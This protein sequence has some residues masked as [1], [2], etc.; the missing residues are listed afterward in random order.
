[1]LCFFSLNCQKRSEKAQFTIGFSQCS[2]DRWRD[3]MNSEMRRELAFHP[4]INFDFRLS[5][6]NNALQ[7][8]QI[9]ALIDLKVDLLI[10]SPN[11]AKPLTPI[12]DEAFKA[13]I[14][15]IL[16]DRKTDSENY[17]A[18]IGADN[19]EIGHTAAEY[20]ADQLGGR[21][22]I[23]ELQMNMAISPAMERDRGF[24]TGLK[25]YPNLQLV[26][27]LEIKGE[28]DLVEREFPVLLK[29]HPEVNIIF[30]QTDL[31]AETAHKS[32]QKVGLADGLF[33]VG[34]DGIP[35]TGQGIQAVEDGILDASLLY[36]TGGGEAIK[37]AISIL[38]GLPFE[39]RNT[40]QTTVIH[41]GNARILHAQMKKEANLA[42]S[43]DKQTKGLKDLTT[44]Y[45]DQKIYIGVL[46]SSLFVSLVLGGFLWKS[47][48]TTQAVNKQLEQ[49]TAEALAHEQLIVGI[50][51]KLET[52]T[53]S[54]VDF[55][56]NISH[57][58]RTP[59]TLILAHIEGL[60]AMG[61]S[62]ELKNDLGMVRKNALRLLRLVNQLMD[63]RKIESDKMAVRAAEQDLP[64]F[65]HEIMAVFKKIAEKRN[66]DF[67]YFSREESMKVWF[68]TQMMDKVLFNLLSNAFKFTKNGGKIDLIIVRDPIENTAVI[69]VEDNGRGMDAA[70]AAHAFDRF[71][72][73]ESAQKYMGTGLGL[74]LSRDLVQLHGG[75]IRL[76][77]ELNVGTRFEIHLPLGRAHF[78]DDQIVR[79]KQ[80]IQDFDEH[81]IFL[82]ENQPDWQSANPVFSKKEAS[83]A[84]NLPETHD[85]TT[86]LIIEDNDELRLFLKEKLGK[87]YQI[88]EA[89]DGEKGLDAAFQN[90]PDLILSDVMMPGRDGLSLTKILKNDLRTS[91]IPIVI[92]TA[93]TAME[94]KITGIQTGADAY[95]TKP[96][97]LVFLLEII[98]NLLAGR[99]SL[100]ERFGG[101][102]TPDK[103]RMAG[104]TGLDEKFL[105][106]FTE[107]IEANYADATLSV[108]GLCDIFGLS[109]VQIY[110]KVK[111]LMG[112]SVND[113]IQ[114]TRLKKASQLLLET[115][116][117][118]SE[119]AYRVG[120]SS[121]GYF[122]TAFK[123]RYQCSPTEWRDRPGN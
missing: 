70:T 89:A 113:F 82:E 7:I 123:A 39:R 86:I 5:D 31:L 103:N 110:R 90:M 30:G 41:P 108:Q 2:D 62:R 66:I 50:S 20:I 111:A 107:H 81:R 51:E 99:E 14:P 116:L 88:L 45:L 53:R 73:G 112:E 40:L 100:R 9:R 122:A 27:T 44:I 74:A 32:A 118:V 98:K 25:K 97:N 80:D 19:F 48:R 42:E 84:A 12:V 68:D 78:R 34:I 16:I 55:F 114:H 38:N 121:P 15:V 23:I 11:E 8:Q 43:I 52:A 21:G 120:Y 28:V 63:F 71:F 59:L 17:T 1:M 36:P 96:F 69:K 57:E 83:R 60:L 33:F 75:D 109:R 64:V 49:K 3:V 85:K 72:Q 10:I 87:N 24:R 106:K 47:L 119:V 91:H 92:L 101:S 22:K 29:K 35:G 18:Y 54:K 95:M 26:E 46:L 67:R 77:S 105:Q 94:A 4:E 6:E 93:K 104:M 117:N 56:T 102:F 61:G 58:F 76:W 115:D 79:E 37:L 65:V 13:G